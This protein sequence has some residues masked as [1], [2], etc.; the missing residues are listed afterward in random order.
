MSGIRPLPG[1]RKAMSAKN[2]TPGP[3]PCGPRAASAWRGAHGLTA[4][5]PSCQYGKRLYIIQLSDF[6]GASQKPRPPPQFPQPNRTHRPPPC[7]P[8][9]GRRRRPP[10][11]RPPCHRCHLRRPGFRTCRP[12][13]A[14]W[15]RCG[16]AA[17]WH[18]AQAPATAAASPRWTPN[19]PAAAGPRSSSTRSCWPG[20][21]P[22]NGACS[23]RPCAGCSWAA[24]PP[25][26]RPAPASA[27]AAGQ[28]PARRHGARCC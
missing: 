23:A 20:P 26:P 3:H 15:G 18:A 28:Q 24:R 22:A 10:A 12:C 8:P 2:R 6:S 7:M 16:A 1:W 25:R 27:A 5:L 13:L 21:A 11:P 4:F 19:Y 9:S 17:S 14:A